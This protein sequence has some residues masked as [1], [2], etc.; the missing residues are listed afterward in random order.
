[1]TVSAV[2]LA[3]PGSMRISTSVVEGVL[4]SLLFVMQ[5]EKAHPPSEPRASGRASGRVCVGR[6]ARSSRRGTAVPRF[7]DRLV[8]DPNFQQPTTVTAAEPDDEHRRRLAIIACSRRRRGKVSPRSEWSR[9][10]HR[11]PGRRPLL[12]RLGV[13]DRV[14]LDESD[15]EFAIAIKLVSPPDDGWRLI[16]RICATYLLPATAADLPTNRL[17]SNGERT[18]TRALA[19]LA[20]G[21][22]LPANASPRNFRRARSAGAGASGARLAATRPSRVTTMPEEAGMSWVS[23]R[24]SRCQLP[25]T[26]IAWSRISP[27]TS[28]PARSMPRH[29][30]SSTR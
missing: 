17:V 7:N 10:R 14:T 30:R 29:K 3:P 21:V 9:R 25:P 22:V 16:S 13:K 8:W 20:A 23:A 2:A 6:C 12:A 19:R 26:S 5:A 28:S 27:R 11:C 4:G 15:T 24:I 18:R 1:V